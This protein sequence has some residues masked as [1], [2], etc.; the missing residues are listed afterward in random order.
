MNRAP[1]G[2]DL[3]SYG[4]LAILLLA[5]L[6]GVLVAPGL[7]R[8]VLGGSATILLP[9]AGQAVSVGGP[10]NAVGA[11]SWA[12]VAALSLAMVLLRCGVVLL[13]PAQAQWWLSLPVSRLSLVVPGYLLSLAITV[14]AVVLPVAVGALAL[15]LVGQGS[16]LLALGPEAVTG[17]LVAAITAVVGT[18]AVHCGA[19]L[20]W[21]ARDS[22]RAAARSIVAWARVV[23]LVGLIGWAFVVASPTPGGSG[24]ATAGSTTVPWPALGIAA[25]MAAG[26]L[27]SALVVLGRLP[28]GTL[29]EGAIAFERAVS[30]ALTM[31]SVHGAGTVAPA[32]F[33]K[34]RLRKRRL[35]GRRFPRPRWINGQIARWASGPSSRHA[36]LSLISAHARVVLRTGGLVP[37]LAFGAVL[38][39]ALLTIP[40][41]NLAAVTVVATAV[42]IVV[43]VGTL[44]GFARELRENPALERQFPLTTR[45]L[46]A[47]LA[48]I[49]TIVLALWLAVLGAV[50]ELVGV[51]YPWWLMVPLA[52]GLGGATVA[53]GFR[54]DADWGA[55]A[56]STPMGAVPTGWLAFALRGPGLTLL[57]ALPSLVALGTAGGGASTTWPIAL[58][59]LAAQCATAAVVWWRS[60]R[61]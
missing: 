2:G 8:G 54:R 37:G 15:E 3:Y 59:Q 7:D 58:A 11:L 18:V 9:T 29:R 17:V 45:G 23:V 28:V 13:T 46:A 27:G 30:S 35:S 48:V 20:A 24:T 22:V 51:G 40:Y 53:T 55:P 4:A 44:S 34:R 52:I 26:V 47:S 19:A 6:F 39:G 38:P 57:V 31:R 60:T 5:E 1:S 41:L 42:V 36:E 10:G 14:V 43:A 61:A 12:A 16:E 49:P 32:R 50:L 21:S 33:G 56:I 25:V